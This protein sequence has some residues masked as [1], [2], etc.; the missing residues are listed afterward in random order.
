MK[1]TL[2]FNLDEQD[3]QMAHLRAIKA[4]NMATALWDMDYY[5]RSKTEH[6][7]DAMPPE[8]YEA[9]LETR[10]ELHKIMSHHSIDLDELIN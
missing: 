3:D 5:L 10:D 2:E 1:A 6:A 7:P 8:V 9:L 4:V